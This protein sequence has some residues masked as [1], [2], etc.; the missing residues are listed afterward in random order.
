MIV[1]SL[2]LS[3]YH[4]S[5]HSKAYSFLLRIFQACLRVSSQGAGYAV[6]AHTFT[7]L[8]GAKQGAVNE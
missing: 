8:V 4:T 1:L 3:I 7:C 2:S 6:S 5:Y